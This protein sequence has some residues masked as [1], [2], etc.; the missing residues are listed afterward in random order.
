LLDVSPIGV[1]EEAAV[2][3][4]VSLFC[5][6]GGAT[7]TISVLL[8]ISRTLERFDPGY[9]T[10]SKVP[11]GWLRMLPES[12]WGFLLSRH[13]VLLPKLTQSADSLAK[14][15]EVNA[16][17]TA[18]EADEYGQHLTSTR[19]TDG[20]KV[21]NTGT[22]EPY[23]S[24]WGATELTH[25]G[26]KFLTPHLPVGKAKVSA[27]RLA[28]YKSP[29]II[30]AKMA[31]SCEAVIDVAGE[32][33]SLNTNCF[34]NPRRDISLNFVG[35]VCNSRMFMFLYDLFFGALRMSGGYYQFQSPQLRVIPIARASA[36]EQK[37]IAEVVD[38]ILA[39]KHK[40][41]ATDTTVLERE[42]DQ[43]V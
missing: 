4:V 38:R 18:G 40:N 35:G 8:P 11:A 16:T 31:K 42:V 33:A 30:F 7:K 39:A 29:K 41:P 23:V 27:R 34:Y 10:E 32:F 9:Y 37:A 17:S 2:Y 43:Q 36:Q 21:I 6:D 28:M 15:G 24:L 20:L 19:G 22:I 12:I 26:N 25:A 14:L 5:K 13:L 3:P 1:F